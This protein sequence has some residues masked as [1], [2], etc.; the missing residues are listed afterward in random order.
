MKSR[1]L[2]YNREVWQMLRLRLGIASLRFTGL[3]LPQ[4]QV[5]VN[6]QVFYFESENSIEMVGEII[7]VFV[8]TISK[9]FVNKIQ[10]YGFR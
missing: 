3:R 2:E 1:K 8:E 10:F 7:M 6:V 5:N 9:L 4:G